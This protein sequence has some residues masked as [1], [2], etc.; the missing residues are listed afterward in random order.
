MEIVIIFLAGM[1][2]GGL[3]VRHLVIMA[4]RRIFGMSGWQQRSLQARQAAATHFQTQGTLHQ[5]D[6]ERMLGV[7]PITALRLLDQLEVDG[8]VRAHRHSGADV[9]Y[10]RP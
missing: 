10:T 1:L 5:K 8:L 7:Q 9:F 6:M 2:V 4:H 3:I